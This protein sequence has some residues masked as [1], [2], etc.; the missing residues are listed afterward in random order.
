M[1]IHIDT[2]LDAELLHLPN[3]LSATEA[4]CT[5]IRL[6][7]EIPW[8]QHTI[9][10]FGRAV[11]APR[12]SSWHGDAGALYTYSGLVL[13]PQP[14]SAPLVDLRRRISEETAA[15]FNSALLNYYRD[16]SNS[17]G[18]H[19]DDEKELGSEPCIASLSLGAKRRFLLR[20]K[21]RKDLATLEFQLGDGDLFVMRGRTQHHWKHQVPKTRRPS[22]ERIN[23]TFRHIQLNEV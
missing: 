4:E 20:H 10:L 16:G 9:Q 2:P 21:T 23:I 18:W 12:L 15:F 19:S 8:Q 1:V 13:E 3:F 6:R 22:G 14:W 5:F 11:N 17:M 7:D